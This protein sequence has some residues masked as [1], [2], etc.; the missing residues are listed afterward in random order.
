M[1]FLFLLLLLVPHAE[2][3]EKIGNGGDLVANGGDSHVMEFRDLAIGVASRLEN[4][5]RSCQ[6]LVGINPTRLLL[7]AY[8]AKI[9]STKEE[10]YLNG[11]RVEGIN[12]PS[13]ERLQ[14]HLPSFL[15]SENR[16]QFSVHEILGLINIPDLLA[17]ERDGLSKYLVELSHRPDCQ[18][19]ESQSPWSK[20]VVL[21]DRIFFQMDL[22]RS[23]L[24]YDLKKQA[25]DSSIAFPSGAQGF[26][27][28]GEDLYFGFERSICSAANPEACFFLKD[29]YTYL[30]DFGF[31]GESLF[32]TQRWF[33][34]SEL[35]EGNQPLYSIDALRIADS[36]SLM[37][38][39]MDG[40]RKFVGIGMRTDNDANWRQ[41]AGSFVA[42]GSNRVM[43]IVN[44][45][46]AGFLYGHFLLAVEEGHPLRIQQASLPPTIYGVPSAIFPVKQGAFAVLGDGYVVDAKSLRIV[47]S[48]GMPIEDV[49]E[50]D[51]FTLVLARGE[52]YLYNSE[53]QL[54]GELQPAKRPYAIA[55]YG[56]EISLFSLSPGQTLSV[57]TVTGNDFYRKRRGCFLSQEKIDRFVPRELISVGQ[58]IYSAYATEGCLMK[59]DSSGWLAWMGISKNTAALL[60]FPGMLVEADKDSR[61]FALD[62]GRREESLVA[63]FAL[64]LLSAY[65]N[66]DETITLELQRPD[67]YSGSARRV[68]LDSTGKIISIF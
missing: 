16:E 14:F 65:K 36:H 55:A 50:Y 52:V 64:D 37:L 31:A 58:D 46:K 25:Q 49:A 7:K 23:L 2:A 4:L 19:V 8:S 9:E 20:K 51:G 44:Q 39:K 35:P 24:V 54:Q 60:P 1:K 28:K 21:G 18:R 33:L 26:A 43:A 48:L 30:Y 61:L 13:E 5:N 47:A 45:Y 62:L 67:E 63:N 53:W 11:R 66:S 6:D 17:G 42:V 41:L 57:E 59:K 15:Q 32:A 34:D 40:Q 29:K 12:Y 10:L 68:N 56:G 27:F 22:P 3:M 38:G